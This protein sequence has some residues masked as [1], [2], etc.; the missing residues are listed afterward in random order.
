MPTTEDPSKLLN[1]RIIRNSFLLDREI[2][3]NMNN[4]ILESSLKPAYKNFDANSTMGTTGGIFDSVIDFDGIDKPASMTVDARN[5]RLNK[6]VQ[7]MKSERTKLTEMLKQCD[8][9]RVLFRK[10]NLELIKSVVEYKTDDACM[11][12]LPLKQFVDK[13]FALN[14]EL[15]KKTVT[16]LENKQIEAETLNN[17]KE[18]QIEKLT[19]N[20][21]YAK[22][23][24]ETNKNRIREL[25][26]SD[27]NQGMSNNTSQIQIKR[28]ASPILDR[29]DI[30][31]Y[32]MHVD[33]SKDITPNRGKYNI[34]GK[35]GSYQSIT[36][37]NLVLLQTS[38]IIEPLT[39]A[40]KQT[41]KLNGTMPFKLDEMEKYFSTTENNSTLCS[42]NLSTRIIPVRRE[43]SGSI[44]KSTKKPPMSSRH[45]Q[46]KNINFEPTKIT[47]R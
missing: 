44:E 3:L 42:N 40:S 39:D 43:R 45:I 33:V 46:T 36:N 10:L 22:K 41:P 47:K 27:N 15:L 1:P 35:T 6:L 19:D 24:L 7:M 23:D 11:N 32:G 16:R 20:L 28:D 25:I 26:L 18:Q 9:E 37:K 38:Q 31:K 30:V 2:Q 34:K 14:Y 5:E 12:N 4:L 21:R 13:N 29:S 17:N 8:N